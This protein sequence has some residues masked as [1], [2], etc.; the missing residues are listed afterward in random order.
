MHQL[1]LPISAASRIA[2]V[3]AIGLCAFGPMLSAADEPTMPKSLDEAIAMERADALPHTPFYDTPSLASSKPGDLLRQEPGIGFAL[4]S[5][6]TAVRILYHSQSADGADV[7]T[8]GMVLIPAGSAPAD[9]WPVM[10]FI[11]TR[12]GSDSSARCSPAE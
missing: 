4:P 9:G 12:P 3:G 10:A 1:K 7:A 5:G 6:A 8:S 2:A 11:R